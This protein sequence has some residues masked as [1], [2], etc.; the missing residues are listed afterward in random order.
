[1]QN[2]SV[3]HQPGTIPIIQLLCTRG[4]HITTMGS[5]AYPYSFGAYG[6]PQITRHYGDPHPQFTSNMGMG[7]P[8]NTG[9]PYHCYTGMLA[10]GYDVVH[11]Q[12][13]DL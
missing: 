2:G 5:H 12:H 4:P 9:S 3:K 6:D 8:Q 11:F 10:L 1:M 7:D 13:F